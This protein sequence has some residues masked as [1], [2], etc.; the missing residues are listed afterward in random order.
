MDTKDKIIAVTGATGQQGGAVARHLLANGWKVRALTAICKNRRHR[1][2]LR[3]APSWRRAI[4]ITAPSSWQL[5]KEPMGSS[6]FRISGYRM[7][8]R[9]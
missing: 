3:L 5:F 2:W 4:W 1:L 6:A 8:V 9:R 7:L